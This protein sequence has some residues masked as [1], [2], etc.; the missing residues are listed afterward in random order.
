MAAR[1]A[2]PRRPSRR[3]ALILL[4][5]AVLAG[6]TVLWVGPALADPNPAPGP[7]P[8]RPGGPTAPASPFPPGVPDP[9]ARPPG[10]PSGPAP[11]APANP[12]PA[13]MPTP[14]PSIPSGSDDPAWWDITGQVRHA[15]ADLIAWAAQQALQPVMEALGRSWLSTPDFTGNDAAKSIW[16]TSLVAANAVF[17]LFIVAGAFVVTARETL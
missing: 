13:P 12:T 6:L 1:I 11:S 14:G 17:V 4:G 10:A 2:R 8:T 3:V 9:G 15:I 7:A 16:T 5:I